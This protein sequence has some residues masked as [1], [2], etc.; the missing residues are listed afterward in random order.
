MNIPSHLYKYRSLGTA[1]DRDYALRILT[2]SEIY[3]AKSTEFND[4]FDCHLHISVEVDFAAHK[5]KLRKLC[6]GL[7]EAELDTQTQKDLH[8]A[9]IRK[10]EQ[11]VNAAIDR[12]NENIGIF[13]MSAKRDDL[14]MWSHYADYHR[15][16][17]I[18]FKT[19]A[20]MLFG[21]D[22]LSVVYVVDYPKLNVCDNPNIEY[23]KQCVRTKS[24]DWKYEEEWRIIYTKNGP[25][26][27]KPEDEELSGVIFGAHILENDKQDVLRCLEGRPRAVKLYQARECK[28]KFML[29]IVPIY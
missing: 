12:I 15:G 8:P 17:C 5:T 18:E 14:L 23:V 10:R 13:S 11:E 21:C 6:P 22:L 28:D 19:T 4:P 7:S 20:G 26:F 27:F 2:H 25:Q 9:N 16:I 3:F 1:K 29:D 24:K